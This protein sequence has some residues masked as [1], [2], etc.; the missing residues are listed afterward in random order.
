MAINFAANLAEKVTE[1][2]P[3]TT[4]ANANPGLDSDFADPSGEKMKALAWFGANDVRMITTN[5][6][7]IVDPTD[8]ILK[9][10]GSTVCGSDMHLFH[11]SIIEMQKG[12]ILG[13]EFCGIIDSVGS[14]I[15]KRKVG[16]KV[17]ASFQTACGEC[18]Y[19]KRKMTSQC[20]K[21]NSS[22][23][24]NAMYG[25]RTAG[26]FGYSHFTGGFAGGQ[27]EY[28]RVPYGDVNLLVI[29]DGV[30][31]EKA[32]YLSDILCTSYHCVVD[33]GVKEGDIVGIWGMG[34]IGI[35]CAKWAFLKG[36]SRVIAI[37][38]DWRLDFAKS[39]VPGLETI[40]FDEDTDVPGKIMK[41]TSQDH[42]G[43]D[44][45]L[46][47]A[48]GEYAKNFVN[49]AMLATG[50]Q[51]DTAEIVNECIKSVKNYGR[52]GITGV[53]AGLCNGF[54]IGAVME[55]GVRLI[56]NGQCS[57]A[58]YWEEILNDYLIPGKIDPLELF[59]THRITTDDIAKCYTMMD[60]H[61]DG[62]VK[63]FV[64][65]K[66]SDPAYK[67]SPSVKSL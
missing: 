60:K 54:A 20:N 17:V 29:P 43:L 49:K 50:L 5:K 41:M 45:A 58:T 35:C 47:C 44:C 61:Q 4:K 30:P 36:A 22:S 46:E 48:A 42:P 19:C 37:D 59:V 52:V 65:T 24:E 27:A 32:L 3:V 12:D 55:K 10:T 15:T 53:Y 57:V 38:R 14:A 11:G 40:N 33:T 2:I 64:E 6:P 8:V 56:G 16:D 51:T 25:H 1:N 7:K 62:M 34:A 39:K 66:F 21:T 18:Y 26:M 28:V 13:H 67:A 63:V 31:N 9:V 23:V